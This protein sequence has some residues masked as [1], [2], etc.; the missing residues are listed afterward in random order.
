MT[1]WSKITGHKYSAIYERQKSVDGGERNWTTRQ[2]VG[3][4]PIVKTK[5]PSGHYIWPLCDNEKD[6]QD[7]YFRVDWLNKRRLVG[8]L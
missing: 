4:D 1:Q 6:W 8:W 5:A 7:F 2:I 3:L